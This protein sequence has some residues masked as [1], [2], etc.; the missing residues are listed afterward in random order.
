MRSLLCL[1]GLL[2]LT[3]AAGLPPAAGQTPSAPFTLRAKLSVNGVVLTASDPLYTI[4]VT[5]TSTNSLP[6]PTTGSTTYGGVAAGRF[7][8]EIP[9]YDT[10]LSEAE[11]AAC[12]AVSYN[13]TPLAMTYPAQGSCPAGSGAITG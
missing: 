2:A 4:V 8:Y 11:T 1:A 10:A 5:D 3:L 6:D 12:I 13:G 9:T 7:E